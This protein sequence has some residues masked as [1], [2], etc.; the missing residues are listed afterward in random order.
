MSMFAFDSTPPVANM[1]PSGLNAS[2]VTEPP[3]DPVDTAPIALVIDAA[4]SD[5]L[6]IVGIW[7]GLTLG[8][9]NEPNGDEVRS[10]TLLPECASQSEIWPIDPTVPI[11]RPSAVNSACIGISPEI[12]ERSSRPV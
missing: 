9:V 6:G 1:R 10:R 12:K 3:M 11:N 7:P 5:I 2:D 8:A 4:M